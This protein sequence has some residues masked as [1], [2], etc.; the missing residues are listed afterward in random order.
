MTPLNDRGQATIEAA[1]AIPVVIMMIA[2]VLIALVATT[3]WVLAHH[4]AEENLLCRTSRPHHECAAELDQFFQQTNL[5]RLKPEVKWTSTFNRLGTEIT[6]V[7]PASFKLR[8]HREI[9]PHL[10]D[11]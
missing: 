6:F 2:A 3:T 1:F 8:V 9:Q 11:N 7:G 5:R 10:T 4:A